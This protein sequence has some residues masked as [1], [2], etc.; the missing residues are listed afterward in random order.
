VPCYRPQLIIAASADQAP[1]AN[2]GGLRT[3]LRARAG[4]PDARSWCLLVLMLL[5]LAGLLFL[6]SFLVAALSAVGTTW[7]GEPTAPATPPVRDNVRE[8]MPGWDSIRRPTAVPAAKDAATPV[9]ARAAVAPQPALAVVAPVVLGLPLPALGWVALH[10][11]LRSAASST[12]VPAGGPGDALGHHLRALRERRRQP[13]GGS[14]TP[15]AASRRTRATSPATESG[16]LR[17]DGRLGQL[18][19]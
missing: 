7:Q 1:R 4:G 12:R 13:S 11:A 19:T 17:L 15:A 5:A 9:S 18:P 14:L 2:H 8:G 10:L 6:A 16:D 3:Q